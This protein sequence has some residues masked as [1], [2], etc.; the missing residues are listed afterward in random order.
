MTLYSEGN[1][2]VLKRCGIILLRDRR[3]AA[4]TK[5][6]VYTAIVVETRSAAVGSSAFD[7]RRHH[8]D[9][10]TAATRWWRRGRVA[11]A[12]DRLRAWPAAAAC[13]FRGFH[14]SRDNRGR[15]AR[16]R[17]R[18]PRTS[19]PTSDGR[20]SSHILHLRIR[21]SC[22]SPFARLRFDRIFR[23]TPCN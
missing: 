8:T 7:F 4:G 6:C 3:S 22:F 9:F 20:L 18:Q 5:T 12:G 21:R 17:P 10:F 15:H 11:S 23:M 13:A 1:S 14:S 16:R 19:P 2:G